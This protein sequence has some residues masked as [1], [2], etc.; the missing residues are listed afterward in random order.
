MMRF[1]KIGLVLI[2]SLW[3]SACATEIGMAEKFEK[4]MRDYNRMLRWQEVENAGMLFI[5]PEQRDMFMQT[6]ESLKK[7]GVRFT[8]YRIL[9]TECLTDK[10]SGGVIAEFDYYTLPSNRIKTLVY[11]QAW[12][13]RDFGGVSGWRIKT[14]LPTFE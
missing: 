14:G 3:L 6:A 12:V 9:T 11:N 13:Y 10:R 7:R 1:L 5:E 2:S 8:D 4:S